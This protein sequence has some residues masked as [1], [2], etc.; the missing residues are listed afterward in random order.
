MSLKDNF[1]KVV[2]NLL[3]KFL[4]EAGFSIK[5]ISKTESV[6]THPVQFEIFEAVPLG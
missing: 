2:I 1:R 3:E 5:L 4:E 6:E